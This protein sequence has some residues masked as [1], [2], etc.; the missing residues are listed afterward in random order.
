MAPEPLAIDWEAFLA[1]D[2]QQRPRLF[3]GA[4]P[5]F[6][7]PLDGDDLAGLAMEPDAEARIVERAPDGW[8]QT[9]GPFAPEDFHRDHPWTL[10][11]QGVDRWSPAVAALLDTLAPI[12]RWRIEDV[13]VS[14][15]TDGGS[16]GPH[17]DNYDV[18]LLQGSGRR[19]WH[20]GGYCDRDCALLPHPTLRLLADFET[21]QEYL[22]ECGDILYLPPRIAHWGIAEGPCTTYSLGLRA[23][24]L[25]DMVSR[26]ADRALESLDNELFYQDRHLEPA[27]R[28][29]EIRSR[30]LERARLQLQAALDQ[31]EDNDWFGELVTENPH[32]EAPGEEEIDAALRRLADAEAVVSPRPGA[33]IAWQ[34]DGDDLLVFT[35]GCALR[36]AGGLRDGVLELAAGKALAGNQLATL[37]ATADGER[38]LAH[39]LEEGA[40]DVD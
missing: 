20:L 39:C 30:D 19:R 32:V 31:L 8:R 4:L 29:G 35:N 25:N 3:R 12:P 21:R 17:Y 18:F 23:P 16:V 14:W 36:V 2:W 10:L 34:A 11:V 24:R 1:R 5:A 6:A 13:M 33:R 38:L 22:L 9:D 28:A 27:R 40:I 15:A 7:P 26:W 37:L